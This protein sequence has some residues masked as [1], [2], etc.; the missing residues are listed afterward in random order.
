MLTGWQPAGVSQVMLLQRRLSRWLAKP[1]AAGLAHHRERVVH[2]GADAK[3]RDLGPAIQV[4]QDIGRLDVPVHL[5]IAQAQ[6]I[7]S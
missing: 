1:F 5:N 3:V 4:H 2:K 7:T 6:R